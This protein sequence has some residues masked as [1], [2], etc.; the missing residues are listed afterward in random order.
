VS[1]EEGDVEDANFVDALSEPDEESPIDMARPKRTRTGQLSAK[2]FVTAS[3]QPLN[4]DKELTQEEPLQATSSQASS[5]QGPYGQKALGKRPVETADTAKAASVSSTTGAPSVDAAS[6]TH[7]LP[8]ADVQ[9]D[10]ADVDSQS[11]SMGVLTHV[12]RVSSAPMD[13]AGQT[14]QR[15]KS[16]LRNLV[17]FD[18]PE[19][20]KRAE[21]HLKAK[22]AQ[23]TI[24]RA[25]T[26]L[27]RKK[28]P[29]GIV[30]KMERMLVR[31]DQAGKDVPDDFDENGSQKVDSRVKDKWRE[32]MVVCRRLD[33]DDA[34]YALQMYKTRVGAHAMW[35]VY[36]IDVH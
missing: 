28:L 36:S 19:D 27:R 18:I 2:S 35:S 5:S 1:A 17:K 11:S 30:L 31:V 9:K 14:V 29:N 32:Y 6:E 15:T 16:N 21:L 13:A 20:S 34:E 10:Q 24:Q 25:S 12:K 33:T 26:K 4:A 3:S 7:L 8:D 23:M 22:A